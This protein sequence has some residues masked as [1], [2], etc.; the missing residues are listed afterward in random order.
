[1]P[2]LRNLLR[3]VLRVGPAPSVLAALVGFEAGGVGVALL[4]LA[5]VVAV[6]AVLAEVAPE[7]DGRAIH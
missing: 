2:V 3:W 1:M 4:G 6:A 5:V 7:R